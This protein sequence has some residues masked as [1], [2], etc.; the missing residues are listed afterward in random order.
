MNKDRL[1]GLVFLFAGIYGF[2]FSFKLPMGKWNEP[3][4]GVFP[5]FLSI[6][7]L[8][9]GIVLFIVSK[10]KAKIDWKKAFKQQTTSWLI[11]LFTAIYIIAL[12][13]L[14]YVITTALYLFALFLFA[15]RI[16]LW[17]ALFL[18]S[19]LSPASWYFFKKVLGIQLP[20]GLLGI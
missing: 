7:L 10:E 17:M 3:G 14:G 11:V 12:E 6:L 18:T 19:I 1:G 2:L 16:K 8:T 15:S 9:I 20:L 13:Q 4:P 5:I